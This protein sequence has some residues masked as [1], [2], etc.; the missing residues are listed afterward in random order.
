LGGGVFVR[1]SVGGMVLVLADVCTIT[2]LLR[3]CEGYCWGM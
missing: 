3:G 2:V 1:V